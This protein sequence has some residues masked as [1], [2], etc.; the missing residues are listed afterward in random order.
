MPPHTFEEGL[1][2][3]AQI[4]LYLSTVIDTDLEILFQIY[5]YYKE[6][7][8]NSEREFQM[9]LYRG[10]EHPIVK[11]RKSNRTNYLED[12]NISSDKAYE[13]IGVFSS[14]IT[15]VGHHIHYHPSHDR[16]KHIKDRYSGLLD[17]ERV[18][19][20]CPY[21]G[22]DYH[23]NNYNNECE[24]DK[25]IAHKFWKGDDLKNTNDYVYTRIRNGC[26]MCK[27]ESNIC[28][29]CCKGILTKKSCGKRSFLKYKKGIRKLKQVEGERYKS[30]VQNGKLLNDMKITHKSKFKRNYK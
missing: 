30:I 5:E 1:S 9:N 29:Y 3:K 14:V 11:L 16:V 12:W 2:A 24:T 27:D 19:W 26:T 8:L 15:R 21:S 4:I 17:D 18:P 28:D 7:T 6:F 23:L 20:C 22:C 13:Y 10:E 25:K